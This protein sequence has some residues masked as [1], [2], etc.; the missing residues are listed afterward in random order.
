[1]GVVCFFMLGSFRLTGSHSGHYSRRTRKASLRNIARR[2]SGFLFLRS[3]RVFPSLVCALQLHLI[4]LLLDYIKQSLST[5]VMVGWSGGPL[6]PR[7][8]KPIFCVRCNAAEVFLVLREQRA[9]VGRVIA[10]VFDGT[11]SAQ[12]QSQSQHVSEDPAELLGKVD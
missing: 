5:F 11:S 10:M 8:Y 9:S 1:M 3:L 12:S 6:T 4:Y 7:K 2:K